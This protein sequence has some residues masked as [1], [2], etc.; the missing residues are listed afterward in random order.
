MLQMARLMASFS[1]TRYATWAVGVGMLL[2][3]VSAPCSA[4]H[5][6][7]TQDEAFSSKNGGRYWAWRSISIFLASRYRR[8]LSAQ[9]I[10]SCC[11]YLRGQEKSWSLCLP[12]TSWHLRM[13]GVY[14]FTCHC[15]ACSLPSLIPSPLSCL[16]LFPF[17]PPAYT[18][19]RRWINVLNKCVSLSKLP[20]NTL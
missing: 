2:R 11:A 18:R 16:P 12:P 19:W 7:N 14:C 15:S 20:G 6:P 4:G 10:C 1:E 9:Q 3:N 8:A 5:M 17:L 13:L